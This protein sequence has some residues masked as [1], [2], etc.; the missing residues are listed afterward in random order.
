MV[1]RMNEQGQKIRNARRTDRKTVALAVDD[2][3]A[4]RECMRM[5]LRVGGFSETI[6]AG[7]VEEALAVIAGR[8]V[9]L[10]VSDWNMAPYDGLDFLRAVRAHPLTQDIPFVLVTASLSEDAWRGA[11]ELGATD[12]LVKPFAIAQLHESADL[13]LTLTERRMAA[14]VVN[15]TRRRTRPR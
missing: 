12:F 7:D 2:D 10:I 4:F 5:M 8:P 1:L 6:G 14:N 9:D 15:F 11:I 13:C 3:G